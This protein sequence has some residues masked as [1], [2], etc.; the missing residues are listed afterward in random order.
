MSGMTAPS[1]SPALGLP[2][3]AE[4]ELAPRDRRRALDLGANRLLGALSQRDR[5]LLR[6]EMQEVTLETWQVLE[7]PWQ[8]IPYVY[9]VTDGLAS[10]V[11]TTPT[12]ERIE[13]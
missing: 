1:R 6:E 4:P 7:A 2:S 12:S 9:F 10:V 8:P 3:R 13:V 5:A 11:G